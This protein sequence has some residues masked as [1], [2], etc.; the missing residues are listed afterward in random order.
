MVGSRGSCHVGTVFADSLFILFLRRSAAVIL[1]YGKVDFLSTRCCCRGDCG[2]PD[3]V[4]ETLSAA[5]GII[6]A[7][8]LLLLLLLL[9]MLLKGRL[10]IIGGNA[11]V[12]TNG[13][14][15]IVSSPLIHARIEY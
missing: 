15:R 4:V 2:W 10:S 12:L 11:V 6:S 13:E 14:R 3:D 9:F 8:R 1:M 5:V 7:V